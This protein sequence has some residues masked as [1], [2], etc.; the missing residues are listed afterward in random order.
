MLKY[1]CLSGENLKNPQGLLKAGGYDGPD[2][3]QGSL[4]NNTSN[5]CEHF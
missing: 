2:C 1:A 4:S 3:K 5:N